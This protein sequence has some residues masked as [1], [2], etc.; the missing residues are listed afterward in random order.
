MGV[1]VILVEALRNV[2]ASA[3]AGLVG[4]VL[5]TTQGSASSLLLD[6]LRLFP[7]IYQESV[8]DSA[9]TSFK[10]DGERIRT[11]VAALFYLLKCSGTE[12]ENLEKVIWTACVPLL[13]SGNTK[14]RS[15]QVEVAEMLAQA[16]AERSDWGAVKSSLAPLC[17]ESLYPQ[18]MQKGDPDSDQHV[19]AVASQAWRMLEKK[20]NVSPSKST[21]HHRE[22]LLSASAVCQLLG[23]LL[24]AALDSL[25][26]ANDI[27]KG[28]VVGK[29]SAQKFCEEFVSIF[30]SPALSMLS[31]PVDSSLRHC[32]AQ[33]LLPSLLTS[34]VKFGWSSDASFEARGV[35]ARKSSLQEVWRCCQT[36]LSHGPSQRQ[37]VYMALASFSDLLFPAVL[38]PLPA[39]MEV[40]EL[41][42]EGVQVFD[43]RNDILFWEE[44]KTGLADADSLTRKRALFILR[45]ALPGIQPTDAGSSSDAYQKPSESHSSGKSMNRTSNQNS[46]KRSQWAEKEAG[47]LGVGAVRNK[48]TAVDGWRQRWDAFILLHETLEEYG[49]HLVEAAWS[50]QMLFL[51]QFTM[52]KGDAKDAGPYWAG[53]LLQKKALNIDVNF[54][55]ISVLWQRGFDHKN[56]QVRRLVMQSFLEVEW[57]RIR[58]L[59]SLLP[60]NVVLGPF[61]EALDDPVHHKDFGMKGLYSSVTAEGAAKFI[62]AFSASLASRRRG[63]FVVRLAKSILSKN[64]GRS[65]LM[66]QAICLEAAALASCTGTVPV[67]NLSSENKLQASDMWNEQDNEGPACLLDL[68]KSMV[69]S[70]KHHFNPSYRAKVCGH[71]L[72][73]ASTLVAVQKVAFVKFASFLTSFPKEQMTFGGSL[74]HLLMSWIQAPNAGSKSDSA[75]QINSWMVEGLHNMADTFLKLPGFLSSAVTDEDVE[76][77]SL[78]ADRWTRLLALGLVNGTDCQHMISMIQTHARQIYSH[79]YMSACTPERLLLLLRSIFKEFKTTVDSPS[80]VNLGYNSYSRSRSIR[81]GDRRITNMVLIIMDEV[82]SYAGRSVAAFWEY[83]QKGLN[84]LPAAVKGKLG[85]P[86]QRRLPSRLT[87]AVLLGVLS[88]SILAEG[89]LW[90]CQVGCLSEIQEPVVTYLWKF[91]WEV[92]TTPRTMSQISAELQLAALEAFTYVCKALAKT[93]TPFHVTA[94]HAWIKL[95]RKT[96]PYLPDTPGKMP[97]GL[98]SVLFNNV[99]DSALIN[100]LGRSRRAV[101][102]GCKWSSADSLLSI[103]RQS[104]SFPDKFQGDESRSSAFSNSTLV[105][106]FRDCIE[107]LESAGEEYFLPLLRSIRWLMRWEVIEKMATDDDHDKYQIMWTLVQAGWSA[108]VD[109]NKRRVAP[110]AAFLSA[111]FHPAVFG[112]LEMHGSREDQE[113]CGPLKWLLNRLIDLGSRSPR[114]MRLTAL[115]ITG[116]WLS[117][118]E[119]A[120]CYMKELKKLSL[121]GGESVDEE[122]DGEIL[123]SD[124]A[125]QEYATLIQSSDPELTEEFT[126][127]EMYVRVT[128]AVMVHTLATQIQNLK[129]DPVGANPLAMQHAWNFGRAFLLELLTAAAEDTDLNKEL[130]KKKSAIHRRKVRVWQMLCILS[131]FLCRE[132]LPQL[133]LRLKKCLHRNNIPSVRQYIETFAAQIFLRFP[134]LIEENLIS[135]LHDYNMKTQALSSYVL[136]AANVLFGTPASRREELIHQVLPAIL[137]FMTSHHHN[138]RSFTQVLIYRILSQFRPGVGTAKTSQEGQQCLHAIASYLEGNADCSRMRAFVEKHLDTFDPVSS[139]TPRGIFGS[140]YGEVDTTKSAEDHPFECATIAVLD[141]VG[142][143]LNEAREE[144]RESMAADAMA[145][146]VEESLCSKEGKEIGGKPGKEVGDDSRSP[147]ASTKGEKD[148]RVLQSPDDSPPVHLDIQ[149]KIASLRFSDFHTGETKVNTSRMSEYDTESELL[150]ES[151]E[152]RAKELIRMRGGRQD[153]IVVASLVGSVPNLAGLARTCEVFKASTL[154]VAD[155]AVAED[156]Q[157]QLISVTAEQ[158]IPLLEVPEVGISS[159]LKRK[160]REGYSI[161]GLEQTANSV[162]VDKYLF[163]KKVVLVLGRESDGIPVDI[164]HSLDTCLE[165]PQLGVIR[166]LNV[167]VSGAIA[168]WEYTR[169]QLSRSSP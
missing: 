109:C 164:I 12:E 139:T 3:V 150:L 106:V 81:Q 18:L 128:V 35:E 122:L 61:L 51:L 19:R 34:S 159:Y 137:P 140:R 144:L 102:Y 71:L 2:P 97:D 89:C 84:D 70:C 127:S 55:W 79:A 141:Q 142:L 44:L 58:R 118:P 96:G 21:P 47:F 28:P 48:F 6:V 14:F 93:T 163:P 32:A 129:P 25:S 138:L 132:D 107:S 90:C 1:A 16:T 169:Q 145:L 52:P 151:I 157:F 42:V 23:T 130:Y 64:R 20:H 160:R 50:H 78:E 168:V 7:D 112:N 153:L 33:S 75:S 67:T 82:K 125:A 54:T 39:E 166:S 29:Y 113:E 15:L 31:Q 5:L 114:T 147:S 111:I 80:E 155:A 74:H 148:P 158:W 146:T 161:L 13:R 10:E 30:L 149:K 40:D 103:S 57:E 62:R 66:T 41:E 17:L 124:S 100:A 119:T 99:G 94:A 152:S 135:A 49:I 105:R 110:T 83:E 126:N 60:E 131:S 43:I 69:D 27:V 8:G 88:I 116:L 98:L 45:K 95:D 85:G 117:F 86:S 53:S 24:S 123:E 165:I 121:Y 9:S 11:Y 59:S 68:L 56:P 162:S 73:V 104:L 37:D 133:I 167:H 22:E 134:E 108:V 120:T 92:V 65:G 87:P 136:I 77:W 76:A 91:A 4:A 154:V 156:R 38:P 63:V 101:L 143:F 36:L 46:S 26:R 115:H 72:R